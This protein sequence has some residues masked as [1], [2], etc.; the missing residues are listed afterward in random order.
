MR[1]VGARP[2][3]EEQKKETR[4]PLENNKG[5]DI[6]VE[7]WEKVELSIQKMDEEYGDIFRAVAKKLSR[8]RE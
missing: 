4:S 8:V 5:F 1:I 6:L 7:D 2:L 3:T